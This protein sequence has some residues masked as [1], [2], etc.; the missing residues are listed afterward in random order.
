MS[1]LN[2]LDF[3]LQ[4]VDYAKLVVLVGDLLEPRKSCECDIYDDE[5]CHH[6]NDH[7][8]K[9]KELKTKHKCNFCKFLEFVK[10]NFSTVKVADEEFNSEKFL[11]LRFKTLSYPVDILDWFEFQPWRSPYCFIG[12][13]T[14]FNK[15]DI[16]TAIKNFNS[17]NE[18]FRKTLICS[19]LVIELRFDLDEKKS[20][21][22]NF[23]N[24]N[25]N[26]EN[27]QME[28]QF[29]IKSFDN[30]S[31][32]LEESSSSS[33]IG[34]KMTSDIEENASVFNFGQSETSSHR[35]LRDSDMS[36]NITDIQINEE[37]LNEKLKAIGS[38]LVYVEKF[39]D[40]IVNQSDITKIQLLLENSMG[41]I[42]KKLSNLTRIINP[43]DEKQINNYSEFLK[44]PL[45]RAS[46]NGIRTSESTLSN[47]SFLS[48]KVVNKKTVSARMH[49]YKGDLLLGLNNFESA[50]FH[51]V[52]A[53]N[54]SKKEQDN[55]WYHSAMEGI[56]IASYFLLRDS[57]PLMSK[58]ELCEL[59]FRDI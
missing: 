1:K 22:E 10:D 44:T 43:I 28:R 11:S 16:L 5:E 26:I 25:S 15:S 3:D 48:I 6:L 55:L 47:S 24:A 14:C 29:S 33:T 27:N 32:N 23:I 20:T 21:Q 56:C 2:F 19:K 4:I 36:L 13:S 39:S 53:S 59:F 54:Q 37:E 9:S 7:N 49:K 40:R 46:Y 17:I 35:I 8:Q 42:H 45:E 51:Y 58:N 18:K 12:Y 31:L 52:Q 34:N 30:K 41:F 57:K 50:L 38:D